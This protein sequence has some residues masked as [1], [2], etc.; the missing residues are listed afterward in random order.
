ML[1]KNNNSD[2]FREASW[3]LNTVMYLEVVLP[4][5]LGTEVPVLRTLLNLAPYTIYR[6]KFVCPTHSE[7]K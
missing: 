4:Y 1:R 5:S 7:A 6:I 2:K 3:L